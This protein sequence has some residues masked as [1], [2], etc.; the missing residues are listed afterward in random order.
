V[1]SLRPLRSS[2]GRHQFAAGLAAGLAGGLAGELADGLAGELADGLGVGLVFGPAGMRYIALLS[3]TRRWSDRWLSWRLGS[4]MQWCYHAG[5]LRIAGIS[6]QF[7]HQELQDYLAR[8]PADP[9]ASRTL[10]TVSRGEP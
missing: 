6:Y 4:F 3:L 7:R 2:K 10:A 9:G 5:L 1:V 8:N